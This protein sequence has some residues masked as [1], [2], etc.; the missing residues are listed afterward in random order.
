MKTPPHTSSGAMENESKDEKLAE[1]IA[2]ADETSLR[3]VMLALSTKSDESLV[4]DSCFKMWAY[5]N[6]NFYGPGD[7]PENRKKD[8]L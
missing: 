1:A 3:A 2:L 8:H 6:F 7:T 5:W 4:I